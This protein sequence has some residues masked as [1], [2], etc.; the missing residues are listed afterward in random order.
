MALMDNN[1]VTNRSARAPVGETRG[2]VKRITSSS[3][4][5]LI[6]V[7]QSPRGELD[8]S[9]PKSETL[10]RQIALG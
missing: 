8:V 6:G 10:K 4:Y 2:V 3:V 9:C 7:A 1:K 5:A